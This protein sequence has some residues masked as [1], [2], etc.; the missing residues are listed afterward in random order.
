MAPTPS[1]SISSRK[2]KEAA[3]RGL[4]SRFLKGVTLG[5]EK[6]T[7]D[8]LTPIGS[9][10]AS[11]VEESGE[12]QGSAANKSQKRKRDKEAEVGRVDEVESKEDRKARKA[13]KARRKAEKELR[14]KRKAEKSGRSSKEEA[15]KGQLKSPGTGKKR[16][17]DKVK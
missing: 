14:R 17:Q 6:V 12:G 1:L 3:K 16:K 13:D 9:T 4:Y 10:S 5:P 11:A 8:D 2:G 7:F 15:V